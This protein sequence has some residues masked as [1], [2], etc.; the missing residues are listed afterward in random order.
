[1]AMTGELKRLLQA[2][3]NLAGNLTFSGI[4][5][6][7]KGLA[8]ELYG[9]STFLGALIRSILSYKTYSGLLTFTGSVESETAA[10]VDNEKDGSLTF[11][12][13]L[14]QAIAAA[15]TLAGELNFSGSAYLGTKITNSGDLTFSGQLSRIVNY[16]RTNTGTITPTGNIPSAW[17][18]VLYYGVQNP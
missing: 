2:A 5:S 12:G 9:E 1:M 3:R 15:R 18:D 16:N 7:V 6:G 14:S 11:S 13:A 10:G 8:K 17:I 4:V